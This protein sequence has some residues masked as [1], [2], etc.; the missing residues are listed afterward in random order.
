MM[1]KIHEK[2]NSKIA[3]VQANEVI[4]RRVQDALDLMVDPALA[5]AK[6][7]IVR[8]ENLAPDFYNLPSGLAGE[9]MQ[10]FVNYQIQL[11][12]VGDFGQ[13]NSASLKALIYESNRS[14]QIFFQP[15]LADAIAALSR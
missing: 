14:G 15:T 3:E 13:V 4:I 2:G 9:I 1:I 11:A 5:G 7:I 6:K 8:Q 12:I 10:K